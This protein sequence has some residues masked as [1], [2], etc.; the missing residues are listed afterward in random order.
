[1]KMS[2]ACRIFLVPALFIV[3]ALQS[4]APNHPL[5][6]LT[7]AAAP[8]YAEEE[9]KA[10]FE[11]VCKKTQDPTI[12]TIDELRDLIARCDKLKSRIEKLEEHVR[13]VPLIRL[14]MARKLFVFT[15]ES[16]ENPT[17]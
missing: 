8:S 14:K 7:G 4:V 5:A 3:C 9:W 10:E 13:K 15:L 2:K 17:H 16:K 12:L 6:A 11:A 1:M